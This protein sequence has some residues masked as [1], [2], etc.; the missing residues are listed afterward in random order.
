[1]IN[2]N[3]GTYEIT[4]TDITTKKVLIKAR[5]EEQAEA[6]VNGGQAIHKQIIIE[7]NRKIIRILEV[8]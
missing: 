8:L 4:F 1:M 6:L 2:N 7:R 5:S 3:N